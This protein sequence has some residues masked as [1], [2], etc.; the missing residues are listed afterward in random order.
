MS[1]SPEF[2][3][4]SSYESH[5][6]KDSEEVLK[7]QEAVMQKKRMEADKENERIR[8]I[9]CQ[10]LLIGKLEN[11]QQILNNLK[12]ENIPLH[13]KMKAFLIEEKD[14]FTREQMEALYQKII[15][16][17]SVISAMNPRIDKFN[18]Q[19]NFSHVFGNGAQTMITLIESFWRKKLNFSE[20]ENE[21]EGKSLEEKAQ[22]KQARWQNFKSDLTDRDFKLIKDNKEKWELLD[23]YVTIL[24]NKD[25]RDILVEE[26]SASDGGYLQ[27]LA[28]FYKKKLVVEN[29]TDRM[30]H[31][32]FFSRIRSGE[33]NEE[34]FEEEFSSLREQGDFLDK[35]SILEAL[36]NKFFEKKIS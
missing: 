21:L 5:T 16:L 29:H 7:E 33:I 22:I 20:L 27:K 15:K 36:K 32:I 11:Y 6:E 2:L 1:N 35:E 17:Q 18:G 23:A 25:N 4:V 31:L 3:K 28:Q 14:F 19:G 30:A 10:Q 24:I 9:S 34:N 26:V 8:N 12:N 13:N